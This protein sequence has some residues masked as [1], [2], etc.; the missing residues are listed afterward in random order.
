M[1][2]EH[3]RKNQPPEEVEFSSLSCCAL[4]IRIIDRLPSSLCFIAKLYLN[5]NHLMSLNGI[6]Q[7]NNLEVLKF[8]FNNVSLFGSL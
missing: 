7:F 4:R 1:L 5:N 6:E 8:D 2:S 3:C